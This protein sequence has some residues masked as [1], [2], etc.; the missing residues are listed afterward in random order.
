MHSSF[1]TCVCQN[2]VVVSFQ[3]KKITEAEPAESV[4]SEQSVIEVIIVSEPPSKRV[5][6]VVSILD[7]L[8]G[9]SLCLLPCLGISST[10]HWQST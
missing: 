5:K 7:L 1:T 4:Q 8:K 9:S 10:K 6:E 3:K 2:P